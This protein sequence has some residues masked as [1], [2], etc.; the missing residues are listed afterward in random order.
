[1]S[2]DRAIQ[3]EVVEVGGRCLKCA[4]IVPLSATFQ[5]ENGNGLEGPLL[6]RVGT[7][8][9]NTIGEVCGPVAKALYFHVV[10]H[11]GG[12]IMRT[13]LPT[14]QHPE[15]NYDQVLRMWEHAIQAT[16]K[17]KDT[18]GHVLVGARLPP[19]VIVSWAHVG[20]EI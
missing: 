2:D 9:K 16:V 5:R 1:M 8:L 4:A 11:V 13:K 18:D 14:L 10:A 12:L 20:A 19:V 3:P 15:E 6:H 17:G 7:D